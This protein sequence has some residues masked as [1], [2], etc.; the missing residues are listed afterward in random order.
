MGVINFEW[1]GTSWN[2]SY[3]IFWSKLNWNMIFQNKRFIREVRKWNEAKF[4]LLF[5]SVF[6]MYSST[7]PA[8]Q[9]FPF[10]WNFIQFC[11]NSIEYIGIKPTI[12]EWPLSLA[13]QDAISKFHYDGYLNLAQV[14]SASKLHTMNI[15]LNLFWLSSVFL[16]K[17]S[18]E[19]SKLNSINWR[20]VHNV[21]FY[22]QNVNSGQICCIPK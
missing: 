15:Q 21:V 2:K 13:I 11:V 12:L 6:L 16:L 7:V 8:C 17:W 20:I 10:E 22:V 1:N 9:R 19:A 4:S 14:S 5:H 3:F 18:D